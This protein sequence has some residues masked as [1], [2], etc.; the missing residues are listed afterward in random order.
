MALSRDPAEGS[1]ASLAAVTAL[2]LSEGVVGLAGSQPTGAPSVLWLA[3]SHAA[4]LAVLLAL[5]WRRRW[6]TAAVA[7][8]VP[9]AF[10]T[11]GWR[12]ARVHSRRLPVSARDVERHEQRAL[13]PSCLGPCAP[14]GPYRLATT[15]AGRRARGGA[16]RERAGYL[17]R[18]LFWSVLG[19]A[20]VVLLG[21]VVRLARRA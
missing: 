10:G 8:V 13:A 21:M 17:S 16:T 19:L 1:H 6:D 12:A 7:T 15:A 14:R 9:G 4:T 11:I 2:F 20:V 5:L 18:R 3:L